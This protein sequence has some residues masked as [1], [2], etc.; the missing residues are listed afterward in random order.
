MQRIH[1]DRPSLSG[2]HHH[3]DAGCCIRRARVLPRERIG[4]AGHLTPL[5]S[6]HFRLSSHRETMRT[7]IG[8]DTALL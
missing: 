2:C 8:D 6:V 4:G 5:L 3:A 7:T 1:D